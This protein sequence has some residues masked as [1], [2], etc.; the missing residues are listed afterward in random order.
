M[1][2]PAGA[3]ALGADGHVGS[4]GA[5][6]GCNCGWSRGE[7]ELAVLVVAMVDHVVK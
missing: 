6:I 3:A 7:P 5:G 2:L 1:V 4:Q